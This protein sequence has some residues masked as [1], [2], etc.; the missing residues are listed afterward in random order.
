M[1]K[2]IFALFVCILCQYTGVFSADFKEGKKMKVLV[3][4]YS[5]TGNTELV[6]KTIAQML[7][8][9]LRKVEEVKERKGIWGFLSGGIDALKNKC[10]DIKPVD[11][12][13][14]NYDLVFVGSP[15]W[16]SKTTPAINAFISKTDF[17]NKNVVV[18]FTLGGNSFVGAVKDMTEKIEKK[19]GKVVGSF[20]IRSS[21]TKDEMIEKTKEA[22]KERCP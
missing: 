8:A 3:I 9:D 14:A 1:K 10:S 6:A 17:K 18:F 19:E 7:N 2:I 22:V 16:A 20:A 4:F 11:F 15:I 5:R 21:K 12:D 13:L